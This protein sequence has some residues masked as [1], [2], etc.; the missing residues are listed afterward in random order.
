[1][2]FSD[3]RTLETTDGLYVNLNDI[4]NVISTIFRAFPSFALYYLLNLLKEGNLKHEK[5]GRKHP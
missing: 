4:L 5:T 2:K 3:I 1:M